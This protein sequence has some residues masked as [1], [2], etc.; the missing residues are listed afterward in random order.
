[1][2]EQNNRIATASDFSKIA[3]M[4]GI[5]AGL[6][7]TLGTGI[8]VY[9]KIVWLRVDNIR[10]WLQIAIDLKIDIPS[11]IY[12][13]LLLAA[14]IAL[15][16][17]KQW[18]R[19]LLT[20]VSSL[21]LLNALLFFLEWGFLISHPI[22]YIGVAWGIAILTALNITVF[23]KNMVVPARTIKA[24]RL[25]YIIIT[26]LI[27]VSLSIYGGARY[28]LLKNRPPRHEPQKIVL[29]SKP[30][31]TASGGNTERRLWDFIMIMP[32]NY[33]PGKI[34]NFDFDF[35][36]DVPFFFR[37]LSRYSLY[38]IVP[39]ADVSIY[40]MNRPTFEDVFSIFPYQDSFNTARRYVHDTI[41]LLFLAV[42]EIGEQDEIF[43]GELAGIRKRLQKQ[44]PE[45]KNIYFY[46]IWHRPNG[47]SMEFMIKFRPDKASLAD[48]EEILATMRYSPVGDNAE[49]YADRAREL[50][51]KGS[52]EDA[53]FE[54]INAL[55]LDWKKPEYHFLYI[56]AL[57][58]TGKAC[59][60][61]AQCE[62]LLEF[63]P[64]NTEAKEMCETAK[65]KCDKIRAER[66][67]EEK[68]NVGK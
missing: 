52:F 7:L 2:E 24:E 21:I 35:G 19:L 12:G 31:S 39:N 20:G 65:E 64:E 29:V 30:E 8:Y 5:F 44:D 18:G 61:E 58:Q 48:V 63:Q 15:M 59:T 11:L 26:F 37:N 46:S 33:S 41:S 1:M 55:Y 56:Q 28:V 40:V 25:V 49:L 47:P 36:K 9:Q 45:G 38:L 43:I 22:E 3:G 6:S 57:M 10:S 68:K 32:S 13:L 54:L 66:E 60:A 51:N 50:I 16:S 67:A 34:Y 62:T 53:Q 17:G 42:P 27:I 4:F 23:R 14:G